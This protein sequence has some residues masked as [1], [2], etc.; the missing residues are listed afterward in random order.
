MGLRAAAEWSVG[1][2]WGHLQKRGWKGCAVEGSWRAAA[3]TGEQFS[4]GLAAK[5]IDY[6]PAAKAMHSFFVSIK[7]NRLDG[8]RG[9]QTFCNYRTFYLWAS[10]SYDF[11]KKDFG[12]QI[13]AGRSITSIQAAARGDSFQIGKSF[14]FGTPIFTTRHTPSLQAG[15][16]NSFGTNF[17]RRG[18]CDGSIKEIADYCLNHELLHDLQYRRMRECN[19]FVDRPTIKLA[20]KIGVVDKDW[21]EKYNNFP[22]S[23]GQDACYFVFG[24]GDKEL[25]PLEQEIRAIYPPITSIT[26]GALMFQNSTVPKP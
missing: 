9:K 1:C 25:N 10:V 16:Y 26:R 6:Y 17:L 7:E 2:L 22:I 11:C 4:M 14:R 15:A 5:D 13:L 18:V 19:R 3:G 24:Q 8:M 23:F 12:W 21:S 20:G